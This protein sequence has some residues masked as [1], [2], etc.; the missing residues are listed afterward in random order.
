L[1]K[2][3]RIKKN[4]EIETLLSQNKKVG[5]SQ[6]SVY[7]VNRPDAAH[8]RF[9]VSVGKKYGTAV[10]RNRIKRQIRE[11]VNRA[12][13]GVLVDFFVIVKP[14][15]KKLKFESIKQTLTNLFARAKIIEG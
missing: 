11:F 6:F 13:I 3:F 1:N 2:E 14:S 9:A 5:N 7:Y 12:E 4:K 15:A 8:F 10:E